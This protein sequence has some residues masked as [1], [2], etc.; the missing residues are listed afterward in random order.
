MNAL[1]LGCPEGSDLQ[2]A[3]MALREDQV[4]V[5]HSHCVWFN[6]NPG[7]LERVVLVTRSLPDA[8]MA[9]ALF[10]GRWTAHEWPAARLDAHPPL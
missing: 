5:G 6:A 8:G 10:D 3:G 4:N 1:R 9:Q 2:H 7:A